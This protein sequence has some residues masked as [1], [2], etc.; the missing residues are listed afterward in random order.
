MIRIVL[1]MK[2]NYIKLYVEEDS[3]AGD[4]DKKENIVNE[5]D[6]INRYIVLSYF[7][8][9]VMNFRQKLVSLVKSNF[10]SVNLRVAFT[11][12]NDLGK[13]F[14]FKDKT[15]NIYMKGMVVY[16]IGCKDCDSFYI[17]KT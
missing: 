4:I 2:L 1:M 8:H 14:P 7:N 15:T 16:Q 13:Q 9:K 12:P 17:G 3:I 6:V 11:T 5:D 10:P